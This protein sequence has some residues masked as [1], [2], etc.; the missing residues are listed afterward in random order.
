MKQQADREARAPRH[1]LYLLL[2]LIVICLLYGWATLAIRPLY[3]LSQN[4]SI[5]ISINATKTADYS[6]D[7]YTPVG[8]VS[9]NIILDLFRDL[10]PAS[11]PE[12][13]MATL[14]DVL[15]TPVAS[16]TIPAGSTQVNPT[17]AGTLSI[18]TTIAETA[19]TENPVVTIPVTPIPTTSTPIPPPPP[20]PKPTKHPTEDPPPPSPTPTYTPT[21]TYTP[22]SEPVHLEIII[23]SI[24]GAVISNISD[25]M[26]EAE[27]WDPAVGTNNGGGITSVT[28]NLYDSIGNTIHTHSDI[29]AS[30]CAFGEDSSC[31]DAASIVLSSG[32][33]TLEATVLT[34]AGEIKTITRI[35]IIPTVTHLE[36][37]VPPSDGTVVTN[38]NQTKFEAEAWDS[39][40]GINNG[41]GIASITFVIYDSLSN[42][43]YTDS[44]VTLLFCAFG[45]DS[46]CAPST[47]VGVNLPTGTYTLEAMAL[48]DASETKAVTRTFTIP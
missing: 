11:V 30:Y 33:Y 18:E 16:V 28:F 5:P 22:T 17:A 47:A 31:N 25:T 48:T 10:D 42:L 43:V 4:Q 27:A 41:D 14:V 13:R 32:T 1:A 26:F 35:F 44:D 8:N 6:P 39:T 7:F 40:V 45:G 19:L 23:P 46:Q 12:D 24:D 3:N 9:L 36:I 29:T 15:Q 34:N 20:P 38:M 2:L 21:A 37:T